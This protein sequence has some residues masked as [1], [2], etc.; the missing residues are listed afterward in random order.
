MPTW[1]II[2]AKNKLIF[3]K[4]FSWTLQKNW[5]SNSRLKWFS[6]FHCFFEK[7][8][9]PKFLSSLS[10]SSRSDWFLSFFLI[11]CPLVVPDAFFNLKTTILMF[12]CAKMII[13]MLSYV[14]YDD[15]DTFL[16]WKTMTNL[17]WNEKLTISQI[18][19]DAFPEIT[20]I[21]NQ[22]WTISFLT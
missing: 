18:D 16:R 14:K 21:H 7:C 15:T 20:R 4:V 3:S 8:Q 11:F 17:S 9:I 1:M 12:C 6:L 2:R 13:L 19:S 22:Y 5:F 10:V